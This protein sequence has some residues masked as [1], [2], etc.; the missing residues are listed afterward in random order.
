M[1]C[2]V[3]LGSLDFADGSTWQEPATTCGPPRLRWRTMHVLMRYLFASDLGPRAGAGKILHAWLMSSWR[4]LTYG[5]VVMWY[6]SEPG[7]LWCWLPSGK[8]GFIQ[9]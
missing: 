1:R 4:G 5:G 9:K 8:T 2:L 7:R 6:R 3:Q